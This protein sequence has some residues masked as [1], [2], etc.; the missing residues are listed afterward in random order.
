MDLDGVERR[1][2]RVVRRVPLR[3]RRLAG[4]AQAL[5]L[6]PARLPHQQPADLG[7]LGHVGDHLLD[8]LVLADLLAERLALV[9]VPDR[10]VEA[11]L[12]EAD[13]ARGN[14][15]PP[16]VDGAHRDQEALALLADPVLD[17]D[18]DVLEVDEAG[19]AGADPQLAVER[20][21]GQPGHAPLHDE[22]GDRP[23]AASPGRPMANT[24]KWS[25]RSASEIQILWPLRT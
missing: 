19:V 11:R 24:R 20:P 3:Q 22:R 8:Q 15:V 1:L 17:R 25:A 9:G 7:A 10:R 6:E 23:C 18:A 4:V 13:G 21:G 2:H 5:V 16:L 14:R 12:G